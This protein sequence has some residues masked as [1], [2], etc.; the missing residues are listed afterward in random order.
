MGVRDVHFAVVMLGLL[1]GVS[2]LYLGR[3]LVRGRAPHERADADG[4]SVFVPKAGMESWYWVLGPVVSALAA[5]RITPNAVT[6]FSLAPALF[7]GVAAAFGWFGLAC[8]LG[9]MA[10]LCDLVDGVLARRTGVASDAGEVVDAAVDRYVEFFLLAGITIYYRSDWIVMIVA[11]AAL[12]G[13]LMVSYTTAKAEAM[14]EQPPRGS[15]RRAERAVYLLLAASLTPLTRV[16]FAGST[17][18]ALRELPMLV[19]LGLVAVVSN[20]SV[21]RRFKLLADAVQERPL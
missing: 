21:V 2:V 7:A 14:G 5:L 9:T 6:I 12:F 4:G 10:A 13:S 19:T 20:V 17:T 3:T 15:M 8:A 16:A 1:V 11:L 18:E